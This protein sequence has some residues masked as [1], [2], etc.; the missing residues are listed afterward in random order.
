MQ[1]RYKS[2]QMDIQKAISKRG[3][4]TG[5]KVQKFIDSEVLRQSEP[6][7]PWLSHKLIESGDDHTRLG[8]GKV[9]YKT[10]YARIQYYKN[11][12]RGKE[13]TAGGGRRG[14]YWFERMKANHLEIILNGAA[15][16]AGCKGVKE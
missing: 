13:G 8:S 1:I 11:A 7:V 16:I 2:I 14:K 4:E 3:L 10:P 15:K 12:G 9:V 6:Y 5:Q